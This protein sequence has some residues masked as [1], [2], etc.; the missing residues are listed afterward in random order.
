[1]TDVGHPHELPAPDGLHLFIDDAS[2]AWGRARAARRA[3][4]PRALA[5][6]AHV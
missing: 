5:V 1:M 6:A 2:T 3:P 4:A